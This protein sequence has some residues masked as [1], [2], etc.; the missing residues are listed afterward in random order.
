MA[1][2]RKRGATWFYTVKR[3]DVLPKPL[4]LSFSDE[5]E[6]DNYVAR[7]EQLLDAGIVPA[8]FSALAGAIVTM[9]DAIREYRK[10]V[11]VGKSDRSLLDLAV[12]EFGKTQ[13]SRVDYQWAEKYVRKAKQEIDRKSV[14]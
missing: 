13:V 7:L 4:N 6:G 14:V 11:S 2:K 5:A 12:S 1:T 10:V 9:G 3:A 8:E